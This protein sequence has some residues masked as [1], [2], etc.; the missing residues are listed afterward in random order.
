MDLNDSFHISTLFWCFP[1]FLIS[2]FVY[3]FLLSCPALRHVS[4][5]RIMVRSSDRERVVSDNR[6]FQQLLQQHGI[7]FSGHDY[8]VDCALGEHFS[9]T[10]S[11]FI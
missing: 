10:G 4:A 5:C 2:F 7:E 6:R 9:L 8:S 3:V 11:V 1:S